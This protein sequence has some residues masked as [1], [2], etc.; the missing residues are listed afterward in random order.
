MS[1]D[2]KNVPDFMSAV[3]LVVA[4]I[5][6]KLPTERRQHF[7]EGDGRRELED[8]LLLF[9]EGMAKEYEP[10]AAIPCY[11]ALGVEFD[12]TIAE[13]FTGIE[14]VRRF[15]YDPT[16]WKFNGEEIAMPQT[17][18]FKLVSVGAQPNFKKVE[19]ANAK[20]GVIPDGQWCDAFKKAFPQPDGNG[21]IGVAKA[22]WV[23]PGGYAS[24]P[25][26]RT[27]CCLSFLWL[28]DAFDADWRWLVEVQAKA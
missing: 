27:G 14:M 2:L 3:V 19:A 7:V 15:G 12:L 17:K 10:V 8:G 6:L 25:Y 22:S 26:V 11:P 4:R 13:P 9:F 24:F 18:Q 1:S 23:R 28:D 21:P 20:E 16:G 5:A